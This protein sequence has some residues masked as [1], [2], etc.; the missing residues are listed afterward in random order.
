MA[1]SHV[2]LTIT[3]RRFYRSSCKRFGH[4]SSQSFQA[5]LIPDLPSFLLE[6][7]RI[8]LLTFKATSAHYLIV[9]EVA[10]ILFYYIDLKASSNHVILLGILVSTNRLDVKHNV[11]SRFDDNRG[12]RYVPRWRDK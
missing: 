9:Q 5:C 6:G 7:I 3:Q 10:Q 8:H 12:N 4:T 11:T 1:I 2:F